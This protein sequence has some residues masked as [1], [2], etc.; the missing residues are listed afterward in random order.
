MLLFVCSLN[1]KKY[2]RVLENLVHIVSRY[3]THLSISHSFIDMSLISRYL[4]N[5]G[6]RKTLDKVLGCR[7]YKGR[8]GLPGAIAEGNMTGHCLGQYQRPIPEINTRQYDKTIREDNTT[9]QYEKTI[10]EDNTRRQYDKTI[11]Q[12]NTTRQYDKTIRQ[13]NTT[14]QYDKTIRQNNTIYIDTILQR[15]STYINFKQ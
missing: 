9:R 13:D 5:R 12:D 11:R 2:K 1:Y 8:V 6:F 15:F 7:G 14:R 10:R 3:P 4:Y